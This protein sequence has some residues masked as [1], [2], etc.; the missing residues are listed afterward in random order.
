MSLIETKL[1]NV[2]SEINWCLAHISNLQARLE[3]LE[4]ERLKLRDEKL[5]EETG[6]LVRRHDGRFEVE[7]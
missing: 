7:R 1:E 5:R 6:V 3:A 2:E 4:G